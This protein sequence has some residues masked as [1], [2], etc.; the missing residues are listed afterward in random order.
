MK[1]KLGLTTKIFIGLLLGAI[2]GIILYRFVPSGFFRDDFLINGVFKVIGKGFL[3]AMQMLVVPL[4][5]CS[6]VCGSM[7]IGDTKKLGRVGVK[8][9]IFYLI[10]TAIAITLAIL[11]G[12]IINPGIGLDMSS[13]QIAETTVSESKALSDVLLDIIPTN[14]IS[15]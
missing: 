11:I 4:V 14:P 7:A 2:C 12:K 3:R 1:K 8:T 10:T 6:L 9:M 5:F 13:I 15:A